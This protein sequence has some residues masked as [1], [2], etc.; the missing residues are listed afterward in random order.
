MILRLRR[1]I[2]AL[3]LFWMVCQG[4]RF[5]VLYREDGRGVQS[6][7]VGSQAE[8]LSFLRRSKSNRR[9]EALYFLQSFTR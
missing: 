9:V 7:S 4:H 8:G 5:I 1:F 2:L 6:Q 3:R